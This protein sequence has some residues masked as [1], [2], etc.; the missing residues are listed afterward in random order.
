M[1]NMIPIHENSL[2][3]VDMKILPTDDKTTIDY[4]NLL[5]NQLSWCNKTED[6]A[7]I[8][9][10]VQKLYDMVIQ[11]RAQPQLIQRC[12]DFSILEAQY[13]VYCRNHNLTSGSSEMP[14]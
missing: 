1:N 3:I 10:K 14:Q 8:T 9:S 13:L 6:S 11:K 5:S 12:C 4:K 7:F 2:R